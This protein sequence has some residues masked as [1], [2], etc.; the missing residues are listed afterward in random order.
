MLV[1]RP[2]AARE[3]H[4]R[5]ACWDGG[6][7]AEGG[8]A[9]GGDGAEARTC[10]A[11][12]PPLR[13]ALRSPFLAAAPP[14]ALGLEVGADCAPGLML[15]RQSTYRHSLIQLVIPKWAVVLLA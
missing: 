13:A 4:P 11:A 14:T 6:R 3:V 5:V 15:Q 12:R 7:G 8:G 1:A 2:R 10:A 9:G